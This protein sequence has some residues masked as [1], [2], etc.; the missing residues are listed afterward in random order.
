[1]IQGVGELT[2]G[3]RGGEGGSEATR[4][5]GEVAGGTNDQGRR[6]ARGEQE[7]SGDVAATQAAKRKAEEL[8]VELSGGG[9][10]RLRRAHHY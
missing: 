3:G 2:G 7:S 5:A 4:S 6:D 9:R 8:G 10:K 1:V